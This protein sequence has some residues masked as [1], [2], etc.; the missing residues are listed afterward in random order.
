MIAKNLTNL[1][2]M[3]PVVV[4]TSPDKASNHRLKSLTDY[5]ATLRPTRNALKTN[6]SSLKR[7]KK[8]KRWPKS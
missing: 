4:S 8:P 3:P 2:K 6:R 5:M 1:S 7:K